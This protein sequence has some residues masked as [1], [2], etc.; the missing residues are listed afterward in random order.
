M[1]PEVRKLPFLPELSLLS[2][3]VRDTVH[4]PAWPQDGDGAGIP[5]STTLLSYFRLTQTPHLEE[6]SE[7]LGSYQTYKIQKPVP[8][9]IKAHN[10]RRE[11]TP[12]A[13]LTTSCIENPE[14]WPCQ[15]SPLLG[16]T[17]LGAAA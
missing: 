9:V 4:A 3:T 12:V 2:S 17:P 10:N 8:M 13:S 5:F 16:W 11:R 14:V 7:D 1:D 15:L 6:A